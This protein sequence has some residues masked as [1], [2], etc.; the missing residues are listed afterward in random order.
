MELKK[1]K[2]QISNHNLEDLL[3][4]LRKFE[5]EHSEIEEGDFR[6]NVIFENLSER[7]EE[8]VDLFIEELE[9]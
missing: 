3:K 2:V 9:Q 8:C 7:H 4:T 5:I 6:T 1:I